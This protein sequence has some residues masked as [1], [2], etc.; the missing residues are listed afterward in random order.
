MELGREPVEVALLIRKRLEELGLEQKDLAT[1]AHVTESY[2]SQLLTRKKRP[3]APERTDLYEK[4]AAVLELPNGTLE[5][6]AIV[7]RTGQLK[8]ALEPAPQPLLKDV[9]ELILGKCAAE[10]QRA[11]RAIFEQ[12]TFGELERLV[13]QKLLDVIKEVAREELGNEGWLRSVA[14]LSGRSYAETRVT[15]LEFLDT[16]VFHL[17][18]SNCTDFLDPLLESWDIDLATF[19]LEFVLNRRLVPRHTKRFEYLEAPPAVAADDEQGFA[20]FLDDPLLSGDATKDELAFLGRLR[21]EGRRFNS[22]YYYRELQ[23]LRDPLHSLPGRHEAR[24]GN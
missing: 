3:P 23:N 9:R 22:L 6:L 7:Q 2:V 16:D 17:S 1:A 11:L 18:R 15:I 20:R 14:K 10:R 13:T 12:Q 21:F 8:R 19:A 24:P 4:F 5:R